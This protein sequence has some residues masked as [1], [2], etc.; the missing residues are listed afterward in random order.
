MILLVIFAFLAGIV[1]VLSP[2]ILPLLPIILSSTGGGKKYKP[3]GVVT[4]FVLSFTFFTLSLSALVKLSGIPADSLR[5][6]SIIV[7]LAF[8]LSLLST[9]AQSV[10][11]MAFGK[12]TG[13][14]PQVH[15][16]S[17][18]TGGIIIGISLGLLWTPCVGP[19][20][21]SVISLAL[22]G[23]VNSQALFIT[24]SYS[25]GTAIPM[26]VIMMAGAAALKKVPWLVKNTGLIQKVLGVFM[27]VT[28]IGIHFN[29]DRRFQTYILNVFPSYGNNLTKLEDNEAVR[30]QLNKIRKE[31]INMN[32]TP[33]APELI[34]GGGWLN[35]EPLKLK[36]LRN[37][38]VLVDFWTYSCINCQRTFPYLKNW[39]SKYEKEGL[40]IIGVH[41]PEFE[42]EKDINNVAQA[43]KDFGITYPVMQDN[44]FATWN[45]YQNRYWPA[46]YL[47]D[48]NGSVRYTHFGEGDYD[49][50]E[51]VIQQLLE[52]LSN[53][54]IDTKIENTKYTVYAKTPELYLGY[55]RINALR[56]P[57][58]IKT[59]T[60]TSYSIPERLPVSTFAYEGEWEITPEYSIPKKGGKLHLKFEAKQVYLV[61]RSTSGTGTISVHLDN[62]IEN[63]GSNVTKG[64]MEI[65]K[66]QLYHLIQLP[67]PGTHDLRLEFNSDGIQ[68]FAFTFG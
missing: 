32:V 67:N 26:L 5:T 33:K 46:K 23:T 14:L 68:V 7:L 28:A 36:D 2:C 6:L 41:S 66:D 57:E 19:I 64:E 9:K 18:F 38:V 1:T 11:E 44:D 35:T 49:E 63:G 48:K 50:T 24:L 30:E 21:A 39:W 4:G 55:L 47:I 56:S 15:N 60:F 65:T 59:D 53:K 58:Q 16:N 42:F 17:G 13:R 3:L 25:L 12:L 61:A 45:A 31:E 22:S 43:L 37:K 51:Q 20:L 40:V 52:E 10:I 54:D 34:V 62:E 27:I 8:G 29:I